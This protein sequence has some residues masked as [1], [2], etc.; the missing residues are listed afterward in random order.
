MIF[1]DWSLWGW[2]FRM[3]L[4]CQIPLPLTKI[5]G[6]PQKA[7][8]WGTRQAHWGDHGVNVRGLGSSLSAVPH[9]S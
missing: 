5:P 9:S 3:C 4:P 6:A 1:Q 7:K 2:G 8:S